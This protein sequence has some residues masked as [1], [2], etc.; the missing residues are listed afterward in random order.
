MICAG[1]YSGIKCLIHMRYNIN[2]TLTSNFLKVVWILAKVIVVVPWSLKERKL[3]SVSFLGAEDV[4]DLIFMVIINVFILF[5]DCYYNSKFR[6][7]Y[8]GVY[9]LVSYYL[10][11]I[12]MNSADPLS[13]SS[14]ST[15][16]KTTVTSRSTQTSSSTVMSSTSKNKKTT[17]KTTDTTTSTTTLSTLFSTKSSTSSPTTIV[18][19]NRPS[20]FTLPFIGEFTFPSSAPCPAGPYHVLILMLYSLIVV[21]NVLYTYGL[22]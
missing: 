3:K 6:L 7:K 22:K 8:I 9:T 13:S 20:R 18:T 21:I 16:P 4:L 19:S 11:W 1:F 14:S 2:K 17:T 5:V 15:T 10:D 12:I